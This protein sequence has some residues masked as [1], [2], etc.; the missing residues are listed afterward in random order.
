MKWTRLLALP[1]FAFALGGCV[2]AIGGEK[3]I[4]SSSDW[5]TTQQ[6]NREQINALSEGMTLSTIKTLMGEPDFSEFFTKDGAQIEVLFYRTHHE[7]GD[8]ETTRNECTPLI[9]KNATLT[10]W[11]DKAYQ[12]L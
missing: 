7:R 4:E 12:N 6:H 8:G 10:G 3:N 5:Q 11:G 2:I 9:F 1:L